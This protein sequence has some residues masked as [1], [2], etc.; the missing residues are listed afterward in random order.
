MSNFGFFDLRLVKP[1][2]E[3]F[4][5]AVSAVGAVELLRKAQVFET[6]AE[7]V[8]DCSLVAGA[9]GLSRRVP[10]IPQHRLERAGR[11]LRRHLAEARAA[12]VFGSEK[13]GLNNQHMSQ[14][15][16]LLNI[17]TRPEHESMNLAQ[18][19][20]VTLW[21]LVRRPWEARRLPGG[22]P[23][24][25]VEDVE[26]ITV[27][28]EEALQECGHTDYARETE[29]TL[30]THQLVRRLHLAARDAPIWTGI[31]R[32][33]LWKIRSGA[34]GRNPSAAGGPGQ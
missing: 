8:A 18:S 2:D 6:L 30:K 16:W 4:R 34:A 24:A 12:V 3:A 25:S 21:E 26:R 15:H 22:P 23:A 28:L 27:L 20:A 31:L 14:C 17:P 29:A 9:T 19:V 32:Q 10:Q 1:Y 11:L 5:E 13:S 33:I 7:A